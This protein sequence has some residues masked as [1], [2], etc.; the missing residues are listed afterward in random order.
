MNTPSQRWKSQQALWVSFSTNLSFLLLTL[1]QHNLC[2]I[3]HWCSVTSTSLLSSLSSYRAKWTCLK[4]YSRRY[5]GLIGLGE[6]FEVYMCILLLIANRDTMDA[7]FCFLQQAPTYFTHSS[8]NSKC[9]ALSTPYT[10]PA[11]QSGTPIHSNF[12]FSLCTLQQVL[13]SGVWHQNKIGGAWWHVRCYFF[14]KW[15]HRYCWY[16]NV[17]D[18]PNTIVQDAYSAISYLDQ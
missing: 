9:T 5:R 1:N 7:K 17:I 15:V 10:V 12:M 11:S 18:T 14:S 8:L 3:C 4:G 16:A 13:C 6:I 2:C